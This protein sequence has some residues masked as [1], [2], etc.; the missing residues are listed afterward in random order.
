MSTHFFILSLNIE[1]PQT[2]ASREFPPGTGPHF[3]RTVCQ[4]RAPCEHVSNMPA[5]HPTIR[6]LPLQNQQIPVPPG[7]QLLRPWHFVVLTKDVIR[8]IVLPSLQLGGLPPPMSCL[9]MSPT[10]PHA[11][12]GL[13]LPLTQSTT[14]LLSLLIYNWIQSPGA[15]RTIGSSS[16]GLLLGTPAAFVYHMLRRLCC[17]LP[18]GRSHFIPLGWVHRHLLHPTFPLASPLL[19]KSVPPVVKMPR[20]FSTLRHS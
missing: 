8:P 17:H 14:I 2:S 12:R 6:Q 7:L 16:L 4:P 19:H 20:V 13:A 9:W 15:S 18:E 11:G 1:H 5:P 3:L 10:A